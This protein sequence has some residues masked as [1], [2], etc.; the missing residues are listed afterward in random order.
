MKN[1]WH[2]TEKNYCCNYYLPQMHRW[3][4]NTNKKS[5]GNSHDSCDENPST[6]ICSFKCAKKKRL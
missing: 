5:K 2:K 1:A 4:W 6:I 3:N